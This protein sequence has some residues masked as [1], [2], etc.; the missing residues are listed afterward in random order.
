[1]ARE[2]HSL[3]AAGFPMGAHSLSRTLHEI[4]VRAMV[5]SEF[6]VTPDHTD[7][8]ERYVLHDHVINYKDA[9]IY[10]RDCE[11]L[12][13]DPFTDDEMESMKQR[14]DEVVERYG[15]PFKGSYG[16]AAGLP[17][18]RDSNQ[19]SFA[20]L[21][22][23]ANIDHFRGLYQWS[24]HF[25]HADSKALRMS[26][27]ERGG[28]S[29]VLTNATNNHLADP[30]QHALIALHRVF[31]A[32]VTAADLFSFYDNLLCS[33]LRI[34]LD[35]ACNLFGDGEKAVDAAEERFQAELAERGMR[36]D[37]ILGEV[38]IEPPAIGPDAD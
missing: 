3:L 26:R 16:W 38:P 22:Q 18:L 7:L 35:K 6:G 29:A 34:L 31:V 21:E 15:K 2:V 25:V 11:A 28:S 33:S 12:G 27:V 9:L 1:M 37:L 17:G 14:C 23:L 4:A 36:F 5:L 20:D 30:G 19:P 24:S 32:M 13:Y 10:Q 8:A